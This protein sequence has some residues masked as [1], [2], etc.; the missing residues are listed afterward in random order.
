MQIVSTLHKSLI[1][2]LFT[3]KSVECRQFAQGDYIRQHPNSIG[4]FKKI[5]VDKA[6]NQVSV[7]YN[8]KVNRER[9][10]NVPIERQLHRGT[11]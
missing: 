11:S 5:I 2:N 4:M 7:R 9:K 10:V 1:I 3:T 8:I 6:I